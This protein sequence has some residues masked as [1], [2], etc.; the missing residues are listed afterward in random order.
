MSPLSRSP[1]AGAKKSRRSSLRCHFFTIDRTTTAY[2]IRGGP[3]EVIPRHVI[4]HVTVKDTTVVPARRFQ[5]HPNIEEVECHDGVEK[6]EGWAF[7][8][9]PKLR[10]VIM[11]GVKVLERSAFDG[12]GALT[13]VD[14]GK[15]ERIREYTFRGCRSL[16]SVDLPSIRII[17]RAHSIAAQI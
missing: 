15:L 8:L 6:I 5:R 16:S 13:Y 17:W 1:E 12:C 10:R 4:T 3:I 7:Q 2:H 9:C 11:P 14:F